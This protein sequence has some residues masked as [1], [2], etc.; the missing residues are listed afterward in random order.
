M[1]YTM[2]YKIANQNTRKPLY[3]RRYKFFRFFF[4]KLLS[5]IYPAVRNY[6]RYFVRLPYVS[7]PT[8]SGSHP[9]PRLSLAIRVAGG[10]DVE[11]DYDNIS[12][13][14]KTMYENK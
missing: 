4:K 5:T 13:V 9:R 3:I 12:A 8:L 6:F 2:P 10:P 1:I 7:A 11:Y 14:Y